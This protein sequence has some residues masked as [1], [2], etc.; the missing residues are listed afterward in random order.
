MDN[1]NG[2][3]NVD[4]NQNQQ[5]YQAYN[6]IQQGYQQ[7]GYT[8]DTYNQQMYG[9]QSY[10]QNQTY[11]QQPY[12]QQQVYNQQAYGQ[13]PYA[14]NQMYGQPKAANKVDV[15]GSIKG[16][17]NEFT[18]KVKG[19]G[20]SLFC[21]LGIIGAML[22]IMVPFMNFTAIHVSQNFTEDR[23]SLKV[24]VADGF[25]LF[26]LSKLSGT[27]DRGFDLYKKASAMDSYGLGNM[28]S[29]DSVADMID[30]AE[31]SLLWEAQEEIDQTIKKSSAYELFGTVHLI[32]KG[33]LAL[34]IT[35][36]L[37]ILSGIGLLIFSV[38]NRKIPKLI[39]A[40]VSLACLVWLMVCSTHFFS[41]I[42]IGAIALIVGIILSV[43]SAFLDKPAYQ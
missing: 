31:D 33:Q 26:E 3:Q 23:M 34:A 7:Q 16:M 35:P 36:W 25:T 30:A 10:A 4:Y 12:G 22:L 11:G 37:I 8:Q 24:K 43:L 14:Q 9:Q 20:I 15:A 29:K 2:S 17:K 32:L 19:M 5:A 1:N 18:G 21:L 28:V 41:I 6:Q 27:T 42:G 39:C 40:G 38:I 13:Q